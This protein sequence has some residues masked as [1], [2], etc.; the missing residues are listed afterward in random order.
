MKIF[1]SADIEGITGITDWSEAELGRAEYAEFRERMTAE[2]A[3]ACDA[4]LAA[5]ATEILVKDAHWTGRN[6]LAERLPRPAR[7]WRGWSG[8]P[9]SMVQ[10]LDASFDAVVMVGWHSGGRSGGNPLAH[11][12][13][14]TGLVGIRVNGKWLSEFRLHAWAAA[15]EGVPVAFVS[16][17]EDLCEEVRRVDAR[18][19]TVAV[20]RGFGAATLALHPAEARERIAAGVR[21]ALERPLRAAPLPLP[22]RFA[23]EVVRKDARDAYRCALYPGARLADPVTVGF[24]TGDWFEVL[25]LLQFVTT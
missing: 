9:Y 23:V 5:G 3:S 24:E 18:I 16:G 15:L 14:S 11:T 13:S 20:S 25:R 19:E 22:P 4:A 6:L 21:R 1:L 10:G 2:V 12:I 17:D 7:L 8:H